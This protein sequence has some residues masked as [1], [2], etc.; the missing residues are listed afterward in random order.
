MGAIHQNRQ[1]GTLAV[2]MRGRLVLPDPRLGTVV[3][4]VVRNPLERGR[5][6]RCHAGEPGEGRKAEQREHK[7]KRRI[8]FGVDAATR[9]PGC[10]N[11]TPN[12]SGLKVSMRAHGAAHREAGGSEVRVAML[13]TR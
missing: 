3:G 5:T 2:S 11:G 7:R 13:S 8:I 12:A 9:F 10:V 6:D 4:A 1:P